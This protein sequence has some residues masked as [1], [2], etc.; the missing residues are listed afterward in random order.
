MLNHSRTLDR[1][2]N[3]LKPEII[4]LFKQ[5]QQMAKWLRD[6]GKTREDI[7]QKLEN[8][9]IE[10]RSSSAVV[11]SVESMAV[12]GVGGGSSS[13][14]VVGSNP[15]SI[16][17]SSISPNNLASSYETSTLSDLPHHNE[18]TWFF[19]QADRATAEN[20]LRGKNHG[21]FLIRKSADGLFAL[22][23]VCNGTIEHC[24][25]FKTPQ[26]HIFQ[27]FEN[28]VKLVKELV[29]KSW[30]FKKIIADIHTIA[31]V[32]YDDN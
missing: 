7:N 28:M 16:S 21:T 6:H 24:K 11:S 12:G 19:P 23:I 4:T 3:A 10:E 17:I 18:N 22:S 29:A 27:F 26:V 31:E 13:S 32:F 20:L 1:D 9:S 2:M 8:W 30:P 15:R 25:I 5:R 14:G